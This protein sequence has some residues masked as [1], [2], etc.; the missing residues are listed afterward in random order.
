M[1]DHIYPAE[2]L[3]GWHPEPEAKVRWMAERRRNERRERRAAHQPTFAA[4]PAE[5]ATTEA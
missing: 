1:E 4:D 3:H 5:P 2:S